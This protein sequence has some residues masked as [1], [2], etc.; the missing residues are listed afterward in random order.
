MK[1]GKAMAV[2]LCIFLLSGMIPDTGVSKNHTGVLLVSA[3]TTQQQ[4]KDKEEEKE[5]IEQKDRENDKNLD[6][7]KKKQKQ[8]KKE[9]DELGDR[10]DEVI[11]R[12]EDLESQIAVKEQ[13]I[14]ESGQALAQAHEKETDQYESMVTKIRYIYENKEKSFLG[15]ILKEK[16]F[17]DVLNTADYVERI[18]QYDRRTMDD[19]CNNRVLIEELDGKLQ[20]E[21]IQLDALQEQAKEEQGKVTELIQKATK[22]L[23][24]YADKIADAEQRAR[25]YEE[26]LKQA[27]KDLQY[28]KKKLAEEIALSQAAANG[29]WRDISQVTFSEGDRKLLANIIYCE[30]GGES[31]EGKLAVGSVVVNRLLSSKFPNTLTG[32][33]YQKNQFSPAA[34]GRLALALEKDKAT[35]AC[36]RAADEAMAGKTNVGTC[37][38]FRRPVEGL[39]GIVIG[40]HIFY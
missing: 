35:A 10:M 32:V 5:E 16:S 25:E 30:A 1:Y 19:Y 24:K 33:V 14:G 13:E 21:K 26:E 28:L 23:E 34:S 18:A 12:L 39:T 29:A 22:T 2:C 37:V 3:T 27:E 38:F 20:Y 15:A 7:L 36:Y 8:L 40:G 17:S 4:I 9:L 31:Y 11:S 6:E